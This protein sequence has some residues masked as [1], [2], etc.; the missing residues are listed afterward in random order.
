MNNKL[1][2]IKVGTDMHINLFGVVMQ[3]E[4]SNPNR[5]LLPPEYYFR[6]VRS[7]LIG[8]LNSQRESSQLS[9]R[10][11]SRGIDDPQLHQ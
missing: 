8:V 2:R 3:E 9:L 4:G 1:K 5:A 11:K 7:E 10:P 6:R